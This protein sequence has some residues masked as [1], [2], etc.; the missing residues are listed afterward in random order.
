M[1]QDDIPGGLYFRTIANGVFQPVD[2]E[3]R[4]LGKVVKDRE[5]F[6]RAYIKENFSDEDDK[7]TMPPEKEP[8][9]R[10]RKPKAAADEED[11]DGTDV[12]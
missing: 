4:I 9:R 6:I 1:R 10:G 11:T 12:L 3:G 7:T 2:A 5:S 8:P